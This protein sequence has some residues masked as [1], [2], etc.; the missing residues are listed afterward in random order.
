MVWDFFL[1]ELD[2]GKNETSKLAKIFILPYVCRYYVC[3][4]VAAPNLEFAIVSTSIQLH[5]LTQIGE[6]LQILFPSV[7]A[8]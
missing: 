1:F 2:S 8:S 3:L 5:L 6:K 7:V 4:P